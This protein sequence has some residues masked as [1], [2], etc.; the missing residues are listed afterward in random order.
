MSRL[1]LKMKLKAIVYPSMALAFA[2]VLG[3]CD[4]PGSAAKSYPVYV[5]VD[6]ETESL[7]TGASC[8]ISGYYARDLKAT[9]EFG[10]CAWSS[11]DTSVAA[12]SLGPRSHHASVSAIA[13]GKATITAISKYGDATDSCVV[14]VS[15]CILEY[16]M[17]L[18]SDGERLY[19]SDYYAN[20][21]RRIE[22]STGMPSTIAGSGK[23]ESIDGTGAA[24]GFSSLYG[25]TIDGNCLYACDSGKIRRIAIGT[26]EVTTLSSSCG[27]NGLAFDGTS[28]YVADAGN[29]QIRKIAIATGIVTTIAGEP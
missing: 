28:L 26:G 4:L 16:P 2:T 7:E 24:A 13:P 5:Y 29:M 15:N 25:M 9:V 8:E 18:A 11:S 19:V 23:H 17:G 20:I 14:S 1:K 21:V 22:L 6:S 10:D 12:V 27:G 3:S